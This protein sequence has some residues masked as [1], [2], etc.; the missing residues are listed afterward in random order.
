[1]RHVFHE[2][3]CRMNRLITHDRALEYPRCFI[4]FRREMRFA[5]NFW[6][7]IYNS[8]QI[9]LIL[10]DDM[11]TGV[12]HFQQLQNAIHNFVENLLLLNLRNLRFQIN[13]AHK[14]SPVKQ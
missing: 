3:A 5:I 13:G 6:C 8:K 14:T 12:R 11:L 2:I 9:S 10:Y 1:M 4:D 7:F